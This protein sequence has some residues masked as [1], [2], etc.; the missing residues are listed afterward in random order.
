MTSSKE[1]RVDNMV[2]ELFIAHH[3]TPSVKSCL[4]SSMKH[5]DGV[6]SIL[7]GHSSLCFVLHG[8]VYQYSKG[9]RT[10][11]SINIRG[12]SSMAY[13]KASRKWQYK[14]M[15]E[16]GVLSVSCQGR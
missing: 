3:F 10:Q 5:D 4:Y 6:R 16:E 15:E 8:E 9:G 7:L 11:E 13:I 1:F 14:R 2:L 12:R